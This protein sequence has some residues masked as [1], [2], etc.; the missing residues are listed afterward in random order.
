[1]I[2]IEDFIKHLESKGYKLVNSNYLAC[3][4]NSA[5]RR[6][7]WFHQEAQE[8]NIFDEISATNLDFFYDGK[9]ESLEQ[10]DLIDRL[11]S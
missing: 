9:I 10:F 6:T 8:L 11:T 1:M 2:T 4:L 7:I 3:T 5:T